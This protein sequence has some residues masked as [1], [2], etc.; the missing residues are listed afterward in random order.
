MTVFVRFTQILKYV[1][2]IPVIVNDVKAS[3]QYR[4]KKLKGAHTH[5]SARKVRFIRNSLLTFDVRVS[6]CQ[7]NTVSASVI[8][9]A[10][11]QRESVR[12]SVQVTEDEGRVR[13]T[14]S[15]PDGRHAATKHSGRVGFRKAFAALTRLITVLI[16]F[17]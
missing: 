10:V 8:K 5:N 13:D 12:A 14:H 16:F 3:Q 6:L 15:S 2:S 11:Q 9:R 7:N 4:C 17:G 1:F